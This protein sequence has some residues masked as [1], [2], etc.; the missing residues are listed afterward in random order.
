MFAQ[1]NW[2]NNIY[3]AAEY[4]TEEKLRA[5]DWFS[6]YITIKSEEGA[7]VYQKVLE[8]TKS[9][10][11]ILGISAFELVPWVTTDSRHNKKAAEDLFQT[12]CNLYRV[13]STGQ[14]EGKAETD[15]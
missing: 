4:C 9:L 6:L 3:L 1:P 7:R 8:E 5:D 14:I 15:W 11:D 13:S 10:K 2:Q 12:V